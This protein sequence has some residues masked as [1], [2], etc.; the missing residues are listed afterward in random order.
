M[1]TTKTKSKSK[2][3]DKVKDL[4]KS[5]KNTI[6]KPVTYEEEIRAKA[7]E[8]Y[9]QRIDHDEQGTADD[10]WIEAEKQLINSED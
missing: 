10:D 4:E 8:I 6:G 9:H 3:S 7:N 2:K 5:K 1:K